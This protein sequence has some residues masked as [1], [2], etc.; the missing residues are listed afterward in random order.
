MPELPEVEAYRR[1]LDSHALKQRIQRVHV[2]DRRILRG[3]TMPALERGL[4][5]R[6][7]VS[8]RRHG[9]HLFIEVE[10]SNWL[11]LHFG[12]TGDLHYYRGGD[13]PRFSRLI[14]DFPRDRHLAFEDA[15]LFG[16][17]SIVTEPDDFIARKR[18]GPDPLDRSFTPARFRALLRTRRGGIKGLLMSQTVVAG[19]GNLYV[20]ETL[21]QTSIHPRRPVA[22]ISDT[23]IAAL[24]RAIRRIL[25]L[26]IERNIADRELPHSYLTPHREDDIPCPKCGSPIV[27]SVVAGRTTYYCSSHQT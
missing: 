13:A 8:T 5:G 18:L 21:Y 14:L 12:M 22:R 20:D 2:P 25:N 24:H 26:V 19:L 9:K 11:Y 1:H 27:R 17:V 6:R 7:L 16:R 4:L 15:R 23:E 10:R 3:I